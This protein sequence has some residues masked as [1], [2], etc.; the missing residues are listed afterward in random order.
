M[1]AVAYDY[2]YIRA[3]PHPHLPCGET[4][5]A[6]LHARRAR[7]LAV[8]VAPD[9]AALAVR[10]PGLDGALL[11]RY[12]RALV[13]VARGDGSPIGRLPPSERFH[14]MVATRSTVLQPT[15][16]RTGLDAAPDEA[17]WRI[18]EACH[19]RVCWPLPGE[20]LGE[21]RAS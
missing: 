14:W 17:F 12:L 3:V 5:A 16:V 1:E 2:A 9:P 10:W 4:V 20:P 21:A 13:E 8:A 7:L 19:L 6:V 11:A 15:P 18:A